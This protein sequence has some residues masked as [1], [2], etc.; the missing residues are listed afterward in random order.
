M[1]RIKQL[2]SV[3]VAETVNQE[4]YLA[5]HTPLEERYL[6][7]LLTN[8]LG[9]IYYADSQELLQEA[10]QVHNDMLAA[11][12]E[13]AAKAMVYA[14]D[15]GY[16]RLQPIWGLAK[17][18]AVN[19]VL[20]ESVFPQVIK[21]PSD[22]FDFM[23]ILDSMGR[24]QGGRVVKRCISKF[25]N[26]VTEY[27]AMKYNGRGRGYNLTDVIKT[28]HPKA[29]DAKQDAIF[30]YLLGKECDP[31]LL[32]Q[33]TAIET[34]KRNPEKPVELIREGRLNWETVTG[35]IQPTPDIWNALAPNLPVFALLRNLNTLDRHEV[36]DKNR[37]SITATLTN[38]IVLQQSR[39]LPFRFLSA[40]Q[41][42]AKP[43]IKD[44]LRQS[45]E[46]SFANLPD[47][48]GKTAV[49]LD[50]SGSMQGK[51]LT[52]GSVFALALFKKTSGESIFWLFDTE[53]VDPQASM[54]D[55]ILSQAAKIRARGGTDTGVCVR[56]LRQQKLA[57]DN[58]I[59]I[60]DEQQNTGSP[61]Y[62]DLVAYRKT[63]NRNAKA[64]VIDLAPYR[65]RMT[66]ATVPNTYYIYGWSDT[67]LQFIAYACQ[68]YQSVADMVRHGG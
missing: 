27:W 63:I 47:I 33:I 36:L 61:F 21:I 60:T 40:F 62:R 48:A 54:H 43:W 50:I 41:Q 8:T 55:S 68:G 32:P 5:Y 9:S 16:M 49:F 38:A 39:I 31:A 24:G 56:A 35:A 29:K 52:I 7:I 13:F 66:P 28:V 46:M 26:S 65:G 23:T 51:Y 25:L 3:G 67:V 17:L 37:A 15:K 45:V 64:F 44:V 10:E 12:V 53:I 58:M 6:Q 2:F 34:L 42:V 22:L 20:F 4:R 14:R 18:S 57:V 59:I 19:T 1:S 30:K 11:D